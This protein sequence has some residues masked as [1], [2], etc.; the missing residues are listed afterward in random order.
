MASELEAGLPKLDGIALGN[1]WVKLR[2]QKREKDPKEWTPQV[3]KQQEISWAPRAPVL[4]EPKSRG[5]SRAY[6]GV[7]GS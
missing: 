6:R 3:R 5:W 7:P 4:M 1:W 2:E